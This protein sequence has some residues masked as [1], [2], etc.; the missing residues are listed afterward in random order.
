MSALKKID[1]VVM[2]LSTDWFREHWALL[3]IRADAGKIKKLQSLCREIVCDMLSGE[4]SYWMISF[5]DARIQNTT[6]QFE[7][8]LKDVKLDQ[9]S[10]SIVRSFTSPANA[11][12]SEVDVV[13]LLENLTLLLMSDDD[14]DVRKNISPELL[15]VIRATFEISNL[16]QVDFI[17]VCVNSQTEWDCRMRSLTNDLPE[18]LADFAASLHEQTIQFVKFWTQLSLRTSTEDRLKLLA[19]YEETSIELTGARPSFPN[20]LATD[21]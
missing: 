13:S 9:S 18:Y 8:A 12:V 17:K 15:K 16:S 5:D 10:S 3:G 20:W 1:Q 19:W 11:D 7:R 4:E 6:Q 2:L 21:V 14:E